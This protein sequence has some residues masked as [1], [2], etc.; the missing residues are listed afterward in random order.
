[1]GIPHPSLQP[2]EPAP[3]FTLP[4]IYRDGTVS[5]ADY[6]GRSPLLLALFRGIYC[7][8]CRRAI[9]QLAVTADKLAATGVEALAVVATRVERARLY[10]RYRPRPRLALAADPELVTHRAFQL[11]RPAMTPQLEEQM[12][13]VRTDVRGELPV[14]LPIPE[15]ANALDEKDRFEWTAQDEQDSERQ[16]PM[17]VGQFL[18]DRDGIIRWANIEGARNG[19]ADMAH[20]PADEEFLAAARSL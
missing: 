5:L 14:P 11:P 15:A 9:A 7:P 6:R 13:S 20:F 8:F 18:V 12:R 3:D 17:L 2:G 4:A 16:L 10:F 19:L 1:M